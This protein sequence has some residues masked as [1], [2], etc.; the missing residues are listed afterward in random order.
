MAPINLNVLTLSVKSV[1]EYLMNVEIGECFGRDCIET[2]T[3]Q[4]VLPF[5]V[6]L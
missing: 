5:F 2:N 4:L 3:H 6:D 1:D